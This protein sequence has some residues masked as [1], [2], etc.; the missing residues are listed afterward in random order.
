M[1]RTSVP[2][3]ALAPRGVQVVVGPSRRHV[4]HF[5][6]KR[7]AA[8]DFAGVEMVHSCFEAAAEMLAR[9]NK[10][11][12]GNLGPLRDFHA[13]HLAGF[14]VLF[15]RSRPMG[16]KRQPIRSWLIDYARNGLKR[17]IL[18]HPGGKT[19]L[20]AEI[21][22]SLDEIP[23]AIDRVD[24]PAKV[25]PEALVSLLGFFAQIPEMVGRES[26]LKKIND[27]MIGKDIRFRGGPFI[28]FF[29]HAIIALEKML[30]AFPGE[31]G[32]FAG[33]IQTVIEVGLQ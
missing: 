12:P 1:R 20:K 24:D 4:D 15:K 10:M 22:P 7:S 26:F 31:K 18:I 14:Q 25:F 16:C 33:G 19:D 30:D 23:G 2:F 29:V 5:D 3:L 32:R 27:K 21:V 9:N 28:F 17:T 11:G 13:R 8:A 6:T